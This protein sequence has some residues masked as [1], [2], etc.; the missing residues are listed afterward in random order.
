[1]V[2]AA[3]LTSFMVEVSV[4]RYVPRLAVDC[5]EAVSKY[6]DEN[7]NSVAYNILREFLVVLSELK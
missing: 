3:Y 4:I 1:M 2:L 6:G 7:E 5:G